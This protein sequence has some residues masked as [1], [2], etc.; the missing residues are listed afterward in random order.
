MTQR[1]RGF[2]PEPERAGEG[3]SPLSVWS[4]GPGSWGPVGRHRKKLD[5]ATSQWVHR[6]QGRVLGQPQETGH[7]DSLWCRLA[8]RD[9]E[10]NLLGGKEPELVGKI[11]QY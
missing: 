3:S 8:L 11:E 2:L 10:P 5:G 4:G 9:V 6:L 1:H 7:A